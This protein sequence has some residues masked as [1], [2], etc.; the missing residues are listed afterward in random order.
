MKNLIAF[1][2]GLIFAIGLGVGGMTQTHIVRGFLDVTGDWNYTLVGVMV[3][4]I[5]VHSILYFLI[6][7]RS[8]PLLESHFHVPTR[9]DIDKKLIIGAAL[10]GL[11]WGWAGICPGP[12]IASLA[13]GNSNFIIFVVAMLSGMIFFKMVETKL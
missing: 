13:S 9:K 11:G 10:F 1:V 2:V 8:S 4:A 7:K 12:G 6:R 5:S 3:G